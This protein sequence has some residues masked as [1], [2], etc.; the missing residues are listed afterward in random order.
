M[1]YLEEGDLDEAGTGLFKSGDPKGTHWF[2]PQA[3]GKPLQRVEAFLLG[4]RQGMA[5]CLSI[6]NCPRR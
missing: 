3:H 1:G 6:C 2:N 4:Y 5:A